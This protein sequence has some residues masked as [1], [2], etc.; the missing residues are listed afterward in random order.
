MIRIP[1]KIK[2]VLWTCLLAAIAFMAV[3]TFSADIKEG[4]KIQTLFYLFW[5]F[6]FNQSHLSIFKPPSEGV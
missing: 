6:A 3:N 5:R 2:L 1:H 4:E